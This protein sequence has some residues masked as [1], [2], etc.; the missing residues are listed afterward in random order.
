M[1]KD[2]LEKFKDKKT[3]KKILICLVIFILV[4]LLL[5]WLIRAQQNNRN[6]SEAESFSK[7]YKDLMARCDNRDKKV[8]DCC[9]NSVSYMAANNL[10]LAGIGCN[11]GF[12]VIAFGCQGSYKWCE[13]IK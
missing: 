8:Y 11:F 12:R 6:K 13:M 5:N 7:Y 4:I 10:K 3:Q 9:F 1:D 2:F